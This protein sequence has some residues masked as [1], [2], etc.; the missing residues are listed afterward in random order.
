MLISWGWRWY[1]RAVDFGPYDSLL[2]KVEG[3][4]LTCTLN[5]PD[6]LNALTSQDLRDLAALWAAL[7]DAPEI[8]AVIITGSGRG[9]CAGGDVRGMDNG[10]MDVVQA[11][12][13]SYGSAAW[14]ALGAVPQ[15][16]IAA[17]N[18]PAVG[19]GLFFLGLA[20]IVLAVPGARFGDPHV[21][22][23]LVAS[24]A[25]ILAPSIGLRHAKAL[26]LTGDLIGADEAQRIGL[27]N[28]IVADEELHDRAVA[29]AHQ[30]ASYPQ[31]AL[32]WT[33]KCMNRLLDQ[34][35]NVAWE[36]ELALEALAAGTAG[37]KEA[38]AAF[39]ARTRTM[40]NQ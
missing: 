7:A 22:V 21:K 3:A 13:S 33:K 23:G 8:R 36:T 30:L 24:G 15:P 12:L 4:V 1:R 34:S 25:G 35:W 27:V 9:F 32:Q 6:S 26:M 17:V 40:P 20:D 5:R 31:E 29:L 19:A 11:A 14:K 16:V 39:A 28:T 10:E 18:G 38:A 37:H 2:V